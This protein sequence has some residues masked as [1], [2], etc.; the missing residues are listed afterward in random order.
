MLRLLLDI[1]IKP[2]IAAAVADRCLGS[3]VVSLR[4]WQGRKYRTAPDEVILQSA[5]PQGLTLVTYD[6]RSIWPLLRTR[7]AANQPHAGVVFV[8]EKT[9]S[10]QDFGGQ[11]RSMVYIWNQ[12]S[13]EDWRDVVAFLERAP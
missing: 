13:D 1:H 4:H 6:V 9:I 2:E 10:Q 8:D 12:R 3:V 11:I 7:A 5:N